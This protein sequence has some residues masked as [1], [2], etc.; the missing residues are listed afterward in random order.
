MALVLDI[1]SSLVSGSTADLSMPTS[2]NAATRIR[3]LG[4][5]TNVQCKP[6]MIGRGDTDGTYT[7]AFIHETMKQCASSG[8]L[9]L[10]CKDF[11]HLY[12]DGTK[13][14]AHMLSE[15]KVT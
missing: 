4:A 3:D 8:L 7:A 6:L 5:N 13:E 15:G 14:V 2:L 12:T 10:K 11:F 9:T 1:G